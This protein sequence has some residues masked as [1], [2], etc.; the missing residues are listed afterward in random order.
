M[1]FQGITGQP[2]SQV[3]SPGPGSPDQA[4]SAESW[5]ARPRLD[6]AG[7]A[8]RPPQTEESSGTF[9]TTYEGA[10]EFSRLVAV[11]FAASTMSSPSAASHR[12]S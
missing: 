11:L 1:R 10:G 9:T 12:H 4:S 6:P 3:S 2:S 8:R 7:S 5:P